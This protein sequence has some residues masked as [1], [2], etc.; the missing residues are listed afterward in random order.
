MLHPT[1]TKNNLREH[2]LTSLHDEIRL[3]TYFLQDIVFSVKDPSLSILS[4]GLAWLVGSTRRPSVL[5]ASQAF[6]WGF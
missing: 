1:A 2:V 4:L 3:S 5:Q 6:G